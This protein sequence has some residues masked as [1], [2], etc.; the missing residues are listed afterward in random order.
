MTLQAEGPLSWIGPE[1]EEEG[2]RCMGPGGEHLERVLGSGGMDKEGLGVHSGT[3]ALR[4]DCVSPRLYPHMSFKQEC[5]ALWSHTLSLE[6]S[7]PRS[8]LQ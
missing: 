5:E 4:R 7:L 6:S 1:T 8:T 3:E 2:G